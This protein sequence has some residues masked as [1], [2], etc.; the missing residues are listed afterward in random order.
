MNVAV[1]RAGRAD[2]DEPAIRDFAASILT[3]EGV[4]GKASLSITFVGADDIADLNERFMGKHG[5]TDVLSFPIEDAS[6]G[7]PPISLRDGPPLELGDI[8]IS[9][10]VVAAHADEYGVAFSDELYLMVTHGVLHILGWDH[11]TVADA[12]AME[13]R[14]ARHLKTIGRNRR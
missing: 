9:T 13:S 4:P 11:Q 2:V 7:A 3:A 6:P 10:E 14:E 12:Q 8:F 5:P 1:S